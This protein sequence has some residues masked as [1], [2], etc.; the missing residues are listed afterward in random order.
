MLVTLWITFPA[1]VFVVE[2]FHFALLPS[3]VSALIFDFTVVRTHGQAAQ[4]LSPVQ[5]FEIACN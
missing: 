5:N 3:N 4:V 2:S 1:P